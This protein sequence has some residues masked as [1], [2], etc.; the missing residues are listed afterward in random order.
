L[1]L[2]PWRRGDSKRQKLADLLTHAT[3]LHSLAALQRRNFS[4]TARTSLLAEAPPFEMHSQLGALRSQLGNTAPFSV[5]SAWEL[6]TYMADVLLRDSDVMSMRHS[7]ELRVP[8]VDRPLIEWLWRQPDAF[9][10]SA[11]RNKPA[12]ADAVADILPPGVANRPKQGF[13]LPFALWMRGPLRAFLD[14]TYSTPSVSRSGFFN[15]PAVQ[16][17]WKT[18]LAGNDPR[19][20]SRIWSLA[21]LI[22]FLNRRA[23]TR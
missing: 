18:Y 19:E 10:I 23:L 15:T 22:A 2:K 5:V 21:I 3:D 7:L 13:T 9:K 6:R 1:L 16:A 20:W 12:L 14:E 4:E 17:R 11:G 8:L